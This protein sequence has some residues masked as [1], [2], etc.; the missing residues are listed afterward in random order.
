MGNVLRVDL[1]TGSAV[2]E[3]LDPEAARQDIGG[4]GLAGRF[5]DPYVHLPWDHP[6][7]PVCLF[8]GP[9]TATVAPTSGRACM[10]SRSP[11]TG[12]FC[13]ASVGGSLGTQLKKAGLDGIVFTGRS[14]RPVGLVV[15]EG[16]ARVADASALAGATRGEVRSAVDPKGSLAVTGPAAENGVLF[17]SVMVDEHHAFGRGG[18]GLCLA[19]KNLKYLAVSGVGRVSVADPAALKKAR[20]DIFRLVAASPVLSGGHGFSCFGTGALYDLMD[21]RRMMPTD[22]FRASRF[23]HAPQLNAVR[24]KEAF[25]TTKHGC[26]GCHIQCKKVAADGRSMPEFET[27]SHFTALLGL[28]DMELVVAANALCNDLGMDTISTAVT[29]ACRA[30]I[31]GKRPTPRDVLET[32]EAIG[33]GR[34]P[35]LALGA[36]RYAAGAGRPEAA[37]AVKGMELPAYDPRGA[38]GMGLAYALSTRGGCHLRAYPVSHEILRKPVATDRFSFQGKARIIKISEDAGAMVDS[39]TACK[40]IFFAAS[41]E[42][43]AA[44]LQAATGEPY[45]AHSLL[46]RGERIY[47]RERILNARLGFNSVHDDIPGRFFAPPGQGGLGPDIRPVPREEFLEARAKYYAVR[48]LTPEGLPTPEKAR[49]LGLEESYERFLDSARSLLRK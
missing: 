27:M 29:L 6:D 49:Q 7:M 4:R 34:E 12:A 5:L 14:E 41:L 3:P 16:Q 48:G 32:I 31:E 18:L 21:S 1:S 42:E 35:L 40:F 38:Y 9:L 47:Y 10:A 30:E 45:T 43:Y 25:R 19:A 28:T 2:R 36:A 44:A 8:A 24:F 22:N 20:E 11:L 15:E 33:R 37:M 46:A 39:L 17:S 13:D 23:E 26:K